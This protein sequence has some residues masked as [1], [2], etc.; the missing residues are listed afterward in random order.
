MPNLVPDQN[1]DRSRNRANAKHK[2]QRDKEL[3][4]ALETEGDALILA[5][6]VIEVRGV[7]G[8]HDGLWYVAKCKHTFSKGSGYKTVLELTKNATTKPASANSQNIITGTNGIVNT[9]TEV[10]RNEPL[11]TAQGNTVP[12]YDLNG[13][14]TK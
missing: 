12:Q 6:K 3:T 9:Q 4:A 10:K 1:A 5:D 14:I 2:K 8:A 11:K 7:A 13:N